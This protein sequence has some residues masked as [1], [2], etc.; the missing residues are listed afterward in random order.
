MAIRRQGKS[1]TVSYYDSQD[2]D[3]P[4]DG[5]IECNMT[6]QPPPELKKKY[7][8]YISKFDDWWDE[9]VEKMN[10]SGLNLTNKTA[11]EHNKFITQTG[12]YECGYHAIYFLFLQ[13]TQKEKTI[14][15]M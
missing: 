10:A 9:L 12:S 6:R 14:G 5:T 4:E 1:I 2:K 15:Y 11:I 13:V 8:P 7:S 3:G